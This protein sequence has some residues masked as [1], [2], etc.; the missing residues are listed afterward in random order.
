MKK[1]SIFLSLAM[2][3]IT[4]SMAFAGNGSLVIRVSGFEN[5]R[6]T[7]QIGLADSRE[8]YERDVPKWGFSIPILNGEAVQRVDDLPHGTYAVKVF[9]DENDNKELDTRIFGIPTERYGFSNDARAPF[10]PPDFDDAAFVLD[11]PE[12]EIRISVK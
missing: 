12:K 8:N 11:A 7:V 2:I 4:G 10:G 9:H 6:G 3:V 5:D 1:I